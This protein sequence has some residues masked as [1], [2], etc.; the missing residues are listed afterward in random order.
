M[1]SQASLA[2]VQGPGL[3]VSSATPGGHCKLHTDVAAYTLCACQNGWHLKKVVCSPFPASRSHGIAIHSRGRP[4]TG[5]P[6]DLSTT[7]NLPLDPT[8]LD[9]LKCKEPRSVYEPMCY[10]FIF[11]L[12]QRSCQYGMNA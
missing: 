11:R 2:G 4:R 12:P 8:I 1:D 9:S 7:V 10:L 5:H 6:S 3:Q